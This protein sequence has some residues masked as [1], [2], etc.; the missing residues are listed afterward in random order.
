MPTSFDVHM[1]SELRKLVPDRNKAPCNEDAHQKLLVYTL[2][3][4]C[5]LADREGE[6]HLIIII[7]AVWCA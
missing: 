2:E 1:E 6:G 7:H 4:A 5:R 3:A